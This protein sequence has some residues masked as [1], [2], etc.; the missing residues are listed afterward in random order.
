MSGT[1]HL[2]I[3][4]SATCTLMLYGCKVALADLK[5]IVRTA[6]A[7]GAANMELRV[8]ATQGI[9]KID[10]VNLDELLAALDPPRR[11]DR[12]DI[13]ATGNGLGKGLDNPESKSTYVSV[14]LSPSRALISV[15]SPD[16]TWV[17]G[18]A[19]ELEILLR[20]TQKRPNVEPENMPVMVA[21]IFALA[22][23]LALVVA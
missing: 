13:S 18:R 15:S 5:A 19:Q 1:G 22:T 10:A 3:Q 8:S 14:S 21:L 7:G 4:R 9:S 6:A 20:E 23:A 12:I 16:E 17:R 2:S 11:L